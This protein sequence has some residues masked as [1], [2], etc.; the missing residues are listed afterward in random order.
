[1]SLLIE[2]NLSGLALD[3]VKCTKTGFKEQACFVISD[4]VQSSGLDDE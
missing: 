4:D 3:S 2:N 1:L